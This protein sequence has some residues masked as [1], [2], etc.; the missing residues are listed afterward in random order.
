MVMMSSNVTCIDHDSGLSQPPMIS[1][2]NAASLLSTVSSQ[3]PCSPNIN[4]STNRNQRIM[5]HN[6]RS[7]PNAPMSSRFPSFF[8]VSPQRLEEPSPLSHNNV[9][10]VSALRIMTSK[11]SPRGPAH[12]CQPWPTLS[13]PHCGTR[14]IASQPRDATLHPMGSCRSTRLCGKLP[15]MRIQHSEVAIVQYRAMTI[16]CRCKV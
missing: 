5:H 12:L 4:L 11:T 7:S 2:H 13:P 16:V 15:R 10:L 9:P 1:P 6:A 3:C 14:S 8:A